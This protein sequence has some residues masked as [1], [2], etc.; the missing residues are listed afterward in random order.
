MI[1]KSEARFKT[2][3]DAKIKYMSEMKIKNKSKMSKS[4]NSIF[5]EKLSPYIRH[6]GSDNS[7]EERLSKYMSEMTLLLPEE[8]AYCPELNPPPSTPTGE[9]DFGFTFHTLPKT[10]RDVTNLQ[11]PIVRKMGVKSCIAILGAYF[12][13][14]DYEFN[15][16]HFWFLDVLTDCIWCAQD[17]YEFPEDQQKIVLSWILFFLDVI[18]GTQSIYF[19]RFTSQ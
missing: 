10:F 8:T 18:R 5:S 12:D 6:Y 15:F 7:S 14:T 17:Q 19:L 13:C 11:V 3:S 2:K 1:R 4:V 9:F 16:L